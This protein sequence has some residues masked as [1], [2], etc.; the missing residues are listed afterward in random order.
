MPLQEF[1]SLSSYSKIIAALGILLLLLIV[2]S[3]GVSVGYN[4]ASQTG[5][6]RI[7]SHGAI[8]NITS[9]EFPN[10]VVRGP[11]RAEQVITVGTSTVVRMMRAP[12]TLSDLSIGRQVVVIG[13][14][15]ND[16]RIQATFIRI[17]PALPATS[18]IIRR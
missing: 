9:I 8:G 13:S 7:Y 4:R 10:M 5:P 14:S 12:A 18:T 3:A 16:G 15:R 6:N 17:I 2:F 1:K 11:N